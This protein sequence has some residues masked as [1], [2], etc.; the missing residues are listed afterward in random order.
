[1][2]SAG[3]VS[4]GN[5]STSS[6]LA[7]SSGSSSTGGGKGSDAD[8]AVVVAIAALAVT[9]GAFSIAALTEGSRFDGWVWIPPEQQILVKP[10]TAAPYW[11]PLADLTPLEAGSAQN[12]EL[13]PTK[14]QLLGHAPLDRVG[15]STSLELGGSGMRTTPNGRLSGFMARYALGCFPFQWLGVLGNARFSAGDDNGTVFD[16]RLGLEL[17]LLPFHLGPVHLGAYGELGH[18]WLMHDVFGGTERGEGA[19]YGGGGL[20]EFDL[21]TRL[22]LLLRGGAAV[23]PRYE[24]QLTVPDD[25]APFAEFSIGLSVY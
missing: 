5:G 18:A 21:N 23:L 11:I 3:G 14:A 16:G 8:A 6:E 22:G 13:V 12:A 1:L 17:R 2:R 4:G 20:L 10:K 24:D 9:T 25:H 15:I 19:Y 7:G